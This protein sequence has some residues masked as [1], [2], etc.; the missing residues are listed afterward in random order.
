M[1]T[2]KI[3]TLRD[4]L[5]W[6]KIRKYTIAQEQTDANLKAVESFYDSI[7]WHIN[8]E[9][10]PQVNKNYLKEKVTEE[11]EK[12]RLYKVLPHKEIKKK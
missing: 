2:I 9:P 3:P 6:L 10:I 11:W 8:R 5:V 12:V 4:F 1:I 7:L